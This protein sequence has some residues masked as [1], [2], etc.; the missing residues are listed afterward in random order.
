MTPF[1]QKNILSY[2]EA[3]QRL[4]DHLSELKLVN[5]LNSGSQSRHLQLRFYSKKHDNEYSLSIGTENWIWKNSQGKK[6]QVLSSELNEYDMHPI[7]DELRKILEHTLI[8]KKIELSEKSKLF[9]IYFSDG[10]VLETQEDLTSENE[11]YYQLILY[12]NKLYQNYNLR[13]QNNS[14]LEE[15]M[16]AREQGEYKVAMFDLDYFR[17]EHRTFT[18]HAIKQARERK[19]PI[20]FLQ[21][22]VLYEVLTTTSVFSF[23]QWRLRRSSMNRTRL[24]TIPSEELIAITRDECRNNNFTVEEAKDILKSTVDSLKEWIKS[25]K[26]IETIADQEYAHQ[27]I[28]RGLIHWYEET[29]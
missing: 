15:V 26:N 6:V 20:S 7:T 1:Y 14:W 5:V 25:E 18:T 24:D 2:D 16:D 4:N 28:F 17:A 12:G 27:G 10:S 23:S 11:S 19:S 29:F 3:S 13:T 22:R 9:Q 8:I 21:A